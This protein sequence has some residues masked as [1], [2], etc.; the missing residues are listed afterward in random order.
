[1]NV[2]LINCQLLLF[3]VELWLSLLYRP[4][5]YVRPRSWRILLFTCEWWLQV[6]S[7]RGT[8]GSWQH[9]ELSWL[10]IG[11]WPTQLISQFG[12]GISCSV[13]HTNK[14][15]RSRFN[16]LHISGE[17]NTF[18]ESL[19]TPFAEIL[20]TYFLSSQICLQRSGI[21]LWEVFERHLR[22]MGSWGC[23]SEKNGP[24]TGSG[25]SKAGNGYRLDS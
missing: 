8:D 23:V 11:Q 21:R 20:Q 1:M 10:T 12:V 25:N 14:P 24:F 3:F 7:N 16:M 18:E 2:I 13:Q 19:A 17:K 5:M 22:G 4:S 9:L 15:N 6:G